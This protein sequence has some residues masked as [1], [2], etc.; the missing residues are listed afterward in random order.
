MESIKVKLDD[1]FA[2]HKEV[3]DMDIH[4]VIK[5]AE[6]HIARAIEDEFESLLKRLQ[7]LTEVE[8]ECASEILEDDPDLREEFYPFNDDFIQGVWSAY[9]CDVFIDRMVFN[10]G[11]YRFWGYPASNKYVGTVGA[12]YTSDDNI[13]VEINRE[14]IDEL[15][16]LIRGVDVVLSVEYLVPVKQK[17]AEIGR[18]H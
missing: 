2:K 16:E 14:H 13:H 8:D 18:F 15:Y 6:F 12:P 11:G 17:T 9:D 3:K 4:S 5:E 10:V 1:L 7:V